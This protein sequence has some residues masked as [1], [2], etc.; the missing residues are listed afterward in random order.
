MVELATVRP[1]QGESA[2]EVLPREALSLD[3]SR[4]ARLLE[5]EGLEV[6][7]ARALLVIDW[8]V[9]VTLFPSGRMLVHT[10]DLEQAREKAV[11]VLRMAGVDGE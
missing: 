3:L 2:I 5:D 8:G 7:D 9:R 1:C 6:I 11:E 10:E 4:C